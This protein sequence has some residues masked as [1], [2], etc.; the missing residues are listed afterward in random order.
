M[1]YFISLLIILPM[2]AV[3]ILVFTPEFVGEWR[4]VHEFAYE[5]KMREF[6]ELYNYE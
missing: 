2:W 6:Y 5:Q 1:N 3:M 4:A